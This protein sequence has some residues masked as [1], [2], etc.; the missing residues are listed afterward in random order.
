MVYI[1]YLLKTETTESEIIEFFMVGFGLNILKI[2][3]PKLPLINYKNI[4]FQIY[5]TNNLNY[6]LDILNVF[7]VV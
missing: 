6:K 7:Y 3:L 2:D 1:F 5:P 4:G